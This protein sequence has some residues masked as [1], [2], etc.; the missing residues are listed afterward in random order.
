MTEIRSYSTWKE[1]V[2]NILRKYLHAPGAAELVLSYFNDIRTTALLASKDFIDVQAS[3]EGLLN[4]YNKKLNPFY[5]DA[6]F[7]MD[8][9]FETAV[10]SIASAAAHAAT[11]GANLS[12]AMEEDQDFVRVLALQETSYMQIAIRALHQSYA[13]G[14]T[15]KETTPSDVTQKTLNVGVA[16]ASLYTELLSVNPIG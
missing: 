14:F 11:K 5:R 4:S 12:K 8:V 13:A 9:V 1:E 16:S 10:M 7:A 6:G 15:L 2:G 3:A